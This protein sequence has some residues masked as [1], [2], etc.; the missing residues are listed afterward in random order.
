M[1]NCSIQ[2]LREA[3]DFSKKSLFQR[4]TNTITKKRRVTRTQLLKLNNYK[5]ADLDAFEKA[6]SKGEVV[7]VTIEKDDENTKKPTTVYIAT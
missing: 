5:A 3:K 2:F 4:I 1:R 6:I 7:G